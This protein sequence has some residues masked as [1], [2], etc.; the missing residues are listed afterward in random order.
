MEM[1]KYSQLPK[2]KI[3]EKV[4]ICALKVRHL[5]LRRIRP[6]RCASSWR[7]PAVVQSRL[8][9]GIDNFQEIKTPETGFI[10]RDDSTDIFVDQR[11][12][13]NGIEYILAGVGSYFFASPT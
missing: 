1:K 12:H 9:Q 3:L 2:V 7:E 8:R 6:N 4:S 10:G 5:E 11:G 13:Q